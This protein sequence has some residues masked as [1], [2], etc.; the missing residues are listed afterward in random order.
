M[1]GS[2]VSSSSYLLLDKFFVPK[3]VT[4]PLKKSGTMDSKTKKSP[5]MEKKK[6]SA[7][8]ELVPNV[9]TKKH[10]SNSSASYLFLSE[11][12]EN[13]AQKKG[14]DDADK[15]HE[16]KNDHNKENKDKNKKGRQYQKKRKRH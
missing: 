14:D 12:E 2:C 13:D 9:L 11:I 7:T 15:E 5:P 6:L 10:D 3:E 8:K 1:S 16:D 4:S